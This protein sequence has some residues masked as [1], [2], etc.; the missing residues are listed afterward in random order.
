MSLRQRESIAG[1]VAREI[2]RIAKTGDAIG[3]GAAY[4]AA[5]DR[6]GSGY[7]KHCQAFADD[8]RKMEA[9]AFTWL[10]KVAA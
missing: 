5:W 4:K 9:D 10:P 3:E 6:A 7:F 2:D 8:A 1:A